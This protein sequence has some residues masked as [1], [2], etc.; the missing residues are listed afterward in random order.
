MVEHLLAKEGAAGSTPVSRYYCFFVRESLMQIKIRKV[1]HTKV[2]LEFSNTTQEVGEVYKLIYARFA[3]KARLPGFRKGKAP[4]ELVSQHID[5]DSLKKTAIKEL[6]E[7]NIRAFLDQKP[8][9]PPLSYPVWERQD[10]NHKGA[11]FRGYYELG[12]HIKLGQYKNLE[13]KEDLPV[14]EESDIQKVLLHLQ[15]QSGLVHSREG[16]VREKDFAYVDIE[17]ACKAQVFF[18]RKNLRLRAGKDSDFLIPQ[19]AER[20]VDMEPGSSD[21]FCVL[22][23][24]DHLL[25]MYAGKKVEVDVQIKLL[26]AEYL[27]LRPLDEEFARDQ[28][29]YESLSELKDSIRKDLELQ[30]KKYLRKQ[31]QLRLLAKVMKNAEIAIP[32]HLLRNEFAQHLRRLHASAEH[33]KG[34]SIEG[35]EGLAAFMEISPDALA[36]QIAEGVYSALCA[37][38]LLGRLA[39]EYG[40]KISEQEIQEEAGEQA[41]ASHLQALARGGGDK[42]ER[43]TLHDEI[44]GY[45]LTDKT[46]DLLYESAQIRSGGRISWK[47]I[48]K[49]KQ[50]HGGFAIPSSYKK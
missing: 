15:E 38:F 33:D 1:S 21:S 39:K 36:K 20:L 5:E 17:L 32:D 43:E 45:L 49:E 31:T 34:E 13:I 18:K 40:I 50:R 27:E 23:R 3:S 4:K 24:K 41:P 8:E 35:I 9:Y 19:I 25:P 37:D 14:I 48:E 28:G 7:R 47:E 29:E 42:E 12:P 6:E 16:K 22:L 46:M 2:E 30:A 44:R 10:I 26:R 11:L